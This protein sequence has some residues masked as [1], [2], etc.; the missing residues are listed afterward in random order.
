MAAGII[1]AEGRADAA[2]QAGDASKHE[3]LGYGNGRE[4]DKNDDAGEAEGNAK[5]ALRGNS[6]DAPQLTDQH[7]KERNACDQNGGHGRADQGR[8]IGKPDQ[9][10][11]HGGCTDNGKGA[12]ACRKIDLP[13]RGLRNQIKRNA[14]H[15]ASQ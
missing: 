1:A 9:L 2:K 10:T 14:G 3:G 13:A 12:P 7:G 6:L 11:G 15:E 8:G 4:A 5:Q